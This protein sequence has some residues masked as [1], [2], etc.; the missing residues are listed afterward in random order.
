MP[1]FGNLEYTDRVISKLLFNKKSSN[2]NLIIIL[3]TQF[4]YYSNSKNI[5]EFFSNSSKKYFQQTNEH[6]DAI[7]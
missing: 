7:F 2:F 6:L 3:K 5:V 1:E 4:H